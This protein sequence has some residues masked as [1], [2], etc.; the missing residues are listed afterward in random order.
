MNFIFLQDG[1]QP[2]VTTEVEK[3]RRIAAGGSVTD[4]GLHEGKTGHKN[5]TDQSCGARK[6]IVAANAARADSTDQM[7]EV[8]EA[9][10]PLFEFGGRKQSSNAYMAQRRRLVVSGQGTCLLCEHSGQCGQRVVA[11]LSWDVQRYF[12]V[13]LSAAMSMDADVNSSE[14]CR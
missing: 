5:D 13:G 7:R 10:Y 14:L 8:N 3:A 1:R 6:E 11:P 9:G 12:D 2:V 4:L